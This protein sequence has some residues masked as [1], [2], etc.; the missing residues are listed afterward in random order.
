MSPPY[1][2][3][4]RIPS[5]QVIALSP[6]YCVLSGEVTNTNFIVFG[7]V[8]SHRGSNPQSTAIEWSTLTIKTTDVANISIKDTQN[9]KDMM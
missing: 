8:L 4:I 9:L 3:I 2:H 5:Q 6:Y 1:G 7:L